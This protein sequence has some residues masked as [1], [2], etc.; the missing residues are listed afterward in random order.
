MKIE[1]IHFHDCQIVR[2]VEVP[3]QDVLAL[4]LEYPV[5]WEA[6]LFSAKTLIFHDV[7]GYFVEEGPFSVVEHT[8]LLC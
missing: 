6:N 5:D 2:I 7:R 8:R 1:D 3:E 4:E